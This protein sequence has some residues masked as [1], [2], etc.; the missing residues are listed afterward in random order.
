MFTEV[1]LEGGTYEKNYSV[2]ELFI[3]GL[4]LTDSVTRTRRAL[5]LDSFCI[6][7][8]TT[9]S[10]RGNELLTIGTIV[11]VF[12]TCCRDQ[13]GDFVQVIAD[14]IVGGIAIGTV[15][16][17][18]SIGIVGIKLNSLAPVLF[19]VSNRDSKVDRQ[20]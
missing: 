2:W 12:K 8:V 13:I 20:R 6:V 3:G 5:K 10:G 16:V 7:K 19:F 11:I 1:L 4:S 9:Q 14:A 15:F 18:F 17:V